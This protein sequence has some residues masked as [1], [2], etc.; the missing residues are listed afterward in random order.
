V[1]GVATSGACRRAECCSWGRSASHGRSAPE[2][3]VPSLE[4]PRGGVPTNGACEAGVPTAAG[5]VPPTGGV[6]RS[7][8]CQALKAPG[9][10]VP[11]SLGLRAE[12]QQLRA[13]CQGGSVP[14]PSTKALNTRSNLFLGVG[15]RRQNRK[16]TP[17]WSAYSCGLCPSPGKAVFAC[18]RG[19]ATRSFSVPLFAR[20]SSHQ[21][22]AFQGRGAYCVHQS[23]PVFASLW[24]W[25]PPAKL[26]VWAPSGKRGLPGSGSVLGLWRKSFLKTF[27]ELGLAASSLGDPS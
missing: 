27:A 11:T 7:A 13:E 5:G 24:V 19:L 20:A 15:A 12:C 14:I 2:G 17:W 23:C 6:P 26:S 18:A 22:R 25:G 9:G 8:G 21:T 1:G 10:R 3:W 16:A 4:G